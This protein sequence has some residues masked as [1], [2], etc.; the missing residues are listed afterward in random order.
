[1]VT[2]YLLYL[3][4]SLVSILL[5]KNEK[6]AAKIGFGTAAVASLYGIFYFFASLG[7]TQSLSFTKGVV[8]FDLS[9]TLDSLGCF[10]SF[11]IVLISFATSIYSIQYSK[12]YKENGNIA[13]MAFMFNIF[14]LSML[15]IVVVENVFWFIVFW[16]VMT[17]TSAF[18]M[19]FQNTNKTLRAVIIYLGIAH[20][21]AF[22]ILAAFLLLSSASGGSLNFSDFA[23]AKL[24]N[25]EASLIFIL[26]LI[27]FGSKIGIFPFHVWFPLVYPTTP[28]NISA[29][30]SGVT[31]KVG[32]FG[33][34]QFCL[35]LFTV[36]Q[37]NTDFLAENPLKWWGL[38][39]IIIG[40]ISALLGALYAIVQDDYKILLAYSSVENIGIILLGIGV[41]VYGFGI[42]SVTLSAIGFLASFYHM[43][44]HSVFKGLLFLSAGN[45]LH[46]TKTEDMNKLGGLAKKM[47]YTAIGMF[48][49]LICIAA[50]P[51]FNGFVS[52]WFTYQGLMQGALEEGTAPRA[53]FSL[54]IVAL[55][56][57][58][59]IVVMQLKLYAVVFGGTP[60]D[61]KIFEDAK[62]APICMIIGVGILVVACVFFG[63]GAQVITEQIMRVVNS[64]GFSYEATTI[65]GGITSPMGSKIS[66][67]LIATIVIGAMML[68]MLFFVLTKKSKEP[69]REDDPWAC[70]FKYNNRMQMTSA[71]FTGDLR[72][73]LDWFFKSK[74]VIE[75]D[76]YFKP[77]KYTRT[78]RDIWWDKIYKPIVSFVDWL[79]H[80]IL[81]M[82]N[83]N[84]N[85]YVIYILIFL[86]ILIIA[87]DIDMNFLNVSNEHAMSIRG[88]Q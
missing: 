64:F 8:L 41:G 22:C 73:I 20:I 66:L 42:A 52:E 82:Q 12:G 67:P 28:T 34:V 85:I 56:L 4:G 7:N 49:G 27:G 18:L 74:P 39:M 38:L 61:T 77:V 69:L 19:F 63:I 1:M 24:T 79:S 55:G 83:G 31:I 43:I 88:E 86:W 40:A 76:G 47:P 10:F 48:V 29:L 33:I 72:K 37:P 9:F 84:A 2:V 57:T 60:R 68:P 58:G 51:P 16:E 13:V 70:G 71:P 50:L 36:L 14:I 15:L 35:W 87:L 62:E 23:N 26:A 78:P 17:I 44:N 6:L 59:A 54:S 75:T 80:K 11:L 30:M 45:T 81:I 3:I 46:V 32:V 53:I 21:G 65:N 25:F 5:Y